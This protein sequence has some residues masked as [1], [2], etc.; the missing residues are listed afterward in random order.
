M[1]PG[2]HSA[3]S[4]GSA[5]FQPRPQCRPRCSRAATR[6]GSRAW[7]LLRQRAG[8]ALSKPGRRRWGTAAAIGQPRSTT[9]VRSSKPSSRN[10]TW[11]IRAGLTPAGSWG[12]AWLRPLPGPCSSSSASAA[13][14]PSRA[15][16]VAPAAEIPGTAAVSVAASST[17]VRVARQHSRQRCRQ[18]PVHG[19]AA[20]GPLRGDRGPPGP[21]GIGAAR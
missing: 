21:A 5:G 14:V 2:T 11:L 10:T 7:P 8:P 17:R 16:G 9:R 3:S 18:A 4:S 15:S 20:T 13:A 1:P 12:R 6:F 19:S